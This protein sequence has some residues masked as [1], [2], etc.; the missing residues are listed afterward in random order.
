M[1]EELNLEKELIF[2][3]ACPDDLYFSWQYEVF[4][5][6]VRRLGYTNEIRVLLYLPFDRVPSGWNPVWDKLEE[7]YKDSNVKFF[8]YVDEDNIL[9]TIYSVQYIPLLRPYVLRRHFEEHPELKDKAIFYH[10]SDIVFTKYLDFSP[11]LKDDVCYLSDT[12]SYI[13]SD[14]WDSKIKDV[15]PD[16][17]ES[18][19][20]IDTLEE[21][22]NLLG[23]N[24]SIVEANKEVSGG[25]QYLLKNIDADFWKD[26]FEGCIKIRKYLTYTIGG[27]N[28]HFFETEDQGYQ[29]WCADMWSVLWNIWKRDVK[30]EIPKE[31]DFAWAT[32]VIEKADSVYLYHDA[33][34]S[35]ATPDLFYKRHYNYV[36]N[37][38]TPFIDDLS[39]VNPKMCS[40][41]YTNEIKQVAEKYYK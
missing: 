4:I 13:N 26:V 41:F 7:R 10:D 23:I 38:S 39:F 3:S 37:T 12:R 11:F 18:F 32:D 16:A 25:A 34:A 14:Y 35:G 31:L 24:R 28:S 22:S 1:I 2:I 27:I 8:R 36:N 21:C 30:T 6:N 33:G 17:L 5:E 40:S 9:H 19:K 29:S 20:L 15:R